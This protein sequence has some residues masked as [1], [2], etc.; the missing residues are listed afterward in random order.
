MRAKQ[1]LFEQVYS[2]SFHENNDE[3]LKVIYVTPI[4][5]LFSNINLDKCGTRLVNFS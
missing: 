2:S 4:E 1:D 5:F 3:D